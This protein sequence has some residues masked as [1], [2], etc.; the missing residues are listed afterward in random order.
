MK[1][2]FLFFFTLFLTGYFL[3]AQIKAVTETGDEVILFDD[4]TWNYLNKEADSNRVILLNPTVFTKGDNA[5]FLLKSTIIPVGIWLDPKKWSFQK[6]TGDTDEEYELKLKEGD[7][8]A[9][10]ITEEVELSQDA[11][12]KIV[13]SNAQEAGSNFHILKEEYR[14]VNGKKVLMLNMTAT[15]QGIKIFYFGYYFSDPAGTVQFITYTTQNLMEK[16]YSTME[17]LLNGLV[18]L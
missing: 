11:L 2:S 6:N 16:Y 1:K 5:S 15:I 14:M 7:V 17:D 4:G 10:I 13:V 18:K 9:I 12:R 8:F 3:Q